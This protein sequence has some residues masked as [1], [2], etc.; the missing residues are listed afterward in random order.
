MSDLTEETKE[1]VE[2]ESKRLVGSKGCR[3]R[4]GHGDKGEVGVVS[5]LAVKKKGESEVTGGCKAPKPIDKCKLGPAVFRFAMPSNSL[6]L[7]PC[8]TMVRCCKKTWCQWG[9]FVESLALRPSR[10]EGVVSDPRAGVL[11]ATLQRFLRV[12]SDSDPRLGG[13]C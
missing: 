12:A 11:S 1:E 10:R 7:N 2:E 5:H 6:C 13:C 9:W 3:E 4:H 8:A